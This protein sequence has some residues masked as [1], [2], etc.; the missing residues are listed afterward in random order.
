MVMVRYSRAIGDFN[1]PGSVCEVSLWQYEFGASTV[2]SDRTN[3]KEVRA[4]DAKRPV[5]F[6]PS[7]VTTV[8]VALTSLD[9][10][11]LTISK[12][13]NKEKLCND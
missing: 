5:T 1:P 12:R 3:H 6:R 13:E 4:A 8:A 11:C 9:T 10:L 7:C 2:Q